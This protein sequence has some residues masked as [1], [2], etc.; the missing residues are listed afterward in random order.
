MTEGRKYPSPKVFFPIKERFENKT[1]YNVK[2]KTKR[3]QSR[4]ALNPIQNLVVRPDTVEALQ[5]YIRHDAR[6]FHQV[7]MAATECLKRSIRS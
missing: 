4:P 2:G 1:N 7:M 5:N 6:D 3:I